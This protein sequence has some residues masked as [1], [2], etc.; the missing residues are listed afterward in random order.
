MNLVDQIPLVERR[1]VREGAG[2]GVELSRTY[3]ASEADLWDSLTDPSRLEHWFEPVSG[4]LAEGGRFE[5]A[6]SGVSGGIST[7][8]PEQLLRLT[9]DDADNLSTV[10]ITLSPAAPG[11]RLTVTHLGAADEHWDT[12]GPAVGGI[13]WD[14]SLVALAFHLAMD[15]E[16]QEGEEETFIR[17]VAHAW[18]RALVDAGGDPAEARAQAERTI[19][20]YLG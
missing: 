4:T 13:G 3:L 17:E 16:S 14:S 5:L 12:H 8:K 1:V 6:G 19:A 11:T 20:F 7:C 9:W 2:V 15:T 10:E 18:S